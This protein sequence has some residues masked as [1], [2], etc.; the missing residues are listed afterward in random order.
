LYS[1][2]TRFIAEFSEL[3]FFP[4]LWEGNTSA[5]KLS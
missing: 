1:D 2:I 4:A 5:P 3:P